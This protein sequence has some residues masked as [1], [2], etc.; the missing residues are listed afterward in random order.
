MLRDFPMRDFFVDSLEFEWVDFFH[1]G[2]NHDGY[3]SDDME[4]AGVHT[5]GFLF[6][7]AVHDL[8]GSKVGFGVKVI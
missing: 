7:V 1:F 8:D 2:G 4:L 3:D 5:L 6:K